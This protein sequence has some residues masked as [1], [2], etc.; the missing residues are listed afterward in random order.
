MENIFDPGFV[1]ATTADGANKNAMEVYLSEVAS[2]RQQ[3]ATYQ[4]RA[5]DQWDKTKTVLAPP[6]VPLL[7]KFKV[8]LGGLAEP[9]GTVNQLGLVAP[10]FTPVEGKGGSAI[11]ATLPTPKDSE[12]LVA[13]YKQNIVINGK[14]DL[15]LAK[16]AQ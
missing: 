4:Q 13:I 11:A 8:G 15:L 9:D 14:L 3:A 1:Q 2:F 6:V 7:K 10:V 16:S 12:L 5:Q